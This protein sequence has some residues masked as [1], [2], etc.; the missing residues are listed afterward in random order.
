MKEVLACCC[1]L[2][3]D[4]AAGGRLAPVDAQDASAERAEEASRVLADV[5]MSAPP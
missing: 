2:R 3:A 4:V 1:R 5:P